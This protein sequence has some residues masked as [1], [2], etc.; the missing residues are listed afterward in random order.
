MTLSVTLHLLHTLEER[1]QKGSRRQVANANAYYWAKAEKKREETM[2][3]MAE[4]N[5]W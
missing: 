3:A 4:E 5:S 1:Q 2:K